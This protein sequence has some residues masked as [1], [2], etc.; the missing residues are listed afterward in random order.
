MKKYTA[1]I[2][3]D[4]LRARTLL[5]GMVHEA[6]QDFEIVA[7]AQDL[8]NGV[9]A[10]R[11]L[12]P[13]LVFL[14]IEMPGHSGLE[15]LDFFNDEEINFSIIFTTAY[16]NYAIQAFKLSA[17]DYLLKPIASEELVGAL[18]RFRK[19]TDAK[20]NAL[21]M[22]VLKENVKQTDFKRIAVPSGNTIKFIELDAILFLKG[23]GSYTE[24]N[25]VD[26]SKLIVSRTLKNFVDMFPENH[27]FV[28]CHKS[29]IVNTKFIC[30]YVKA[31]GGYFVLPGNQHVS[32]S[33]DRVDEILKL[34]TFISR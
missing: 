2:I 21:D 18:D 25:F 16:S 30:E 15:L 9:K 28:R 24:I 19:K 13:D 27:P 31:D 33:P 12:N 17:I 22:A 26:Q 14:D 32:V 20:N 6:A 4:E 7:E 1:I 8:P 34:V 10:I 5:A 3:D 11:K 23:E 29:F